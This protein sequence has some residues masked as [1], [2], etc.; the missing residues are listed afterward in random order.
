M[1]QGQSLRI[2]FALLGMLG[3]LFGAVSSVKAEDYYWIVPFPQPADTRYPSYVT[4]CNA[5]H[6]FYVSSN[7]GAGLVR[8]AQEIIKIEEGGYRC[9]TRGYRLDSNGKEYNS[10][11]WSNVTQRRGTGCTDPNIYNEQTGGCEPPPVNCEPKAGQHTTWSM[12]RPDLNGLGPIEYGCEAGCRIALG[13][14]QCAPVSEGATTGV[15]WGVGTFTGAQCQPGDNP[16]GGNPPTDP[17]DPTDPPPEC[18]PNHSWSGTT[19]VPDEPKECDPSTG[20]VCPPSDGDDDD[21]DGD[22]DDSDGDGD[23][24]GNG[25]GDG[26]GEGDGEGDGDGE[27]TGDGEGD[28]GKCDPKTDPNKCVKPSVEG[29]ACDAELKCEGDVIQCAILRANKNQICQWKYDD[30]VRSDIASELAGKD[31]QLEEKSLAVSSL[32]TEAVNKGRW[33]PQSCPSPQS[34]SVMGRSYSFSWEPACR[35]A[36][37][38]GPLIVA[39]A[40]IFFAVSIG[41]GIKGS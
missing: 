17:T 6:Q 4:A 12:L 25:D 26:E 34:F 24:D 27:G 14:S 13:T 29:E 20:E 28:D 3:G 7:A 40:S 35:F 10:N 18:G 23:G 15:C 1:R 32:F 33:L 16:T 8:F 22:G 21:D 9:Q 31:Y 37:A 41:R 5:N 19:C 11:T 39:L 30:K 36:Q 2:A 38:I